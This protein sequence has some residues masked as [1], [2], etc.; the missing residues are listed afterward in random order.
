M[1]CSSQGE[2][3]CGG[4]NAMAQVAQG[5][6][7]AEGFDV[8]L[9][10]SVLRVARL[11]G[12]PFVVNAWILHPW[13]WPPRTPG[14]VLGCALLVLQLYLWFAQIRLLRAGTVLRIDRVGVTVTGER[15]VPW[16]DLDRVTVARG[17]CVAFHAKWPDRELPLPYYG[18]RHRSGRRLR[19]RLTRRFGTPLVFVPGV[20]NVELRDFVGAVRAYSGGLPVFD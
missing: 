2:R 15:T 6:S 20:C 19:R 1:C 10:W 5:K 7:Q 12:W 17:R 11:A 4:L 16:G 3:S 13:S 14:L 9:R 18:A 8:R